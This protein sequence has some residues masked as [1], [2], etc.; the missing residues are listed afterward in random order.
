M[1]T[2]T[3]VVLPENAVVR[4]SSDAK[5]SENSRHNNIDLVELNNAVRALE[6]I[7]E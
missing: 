3:E 1:S 6:E 7:S 5:F 4:H 2:T